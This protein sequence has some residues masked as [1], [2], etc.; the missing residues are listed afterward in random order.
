MIS[1]KVVTLQMQ[2]ISVSIQVRVWYI[3]NVEKDSSIHRNFIGS[4]QIKSIRW[5]KLIDGKTETH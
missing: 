5:I 3:Q 1:P 4:D 2:Y